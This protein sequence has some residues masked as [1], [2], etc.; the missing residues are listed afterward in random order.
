[1]G[2]FVWIQLWKRNKGSFMRNTIELLEQE[3]LKESFVEETR[4]SGSFVKIKISE[5][6]LHRRK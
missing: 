6:A 2:I 5:I 1:M 4:E 3:G